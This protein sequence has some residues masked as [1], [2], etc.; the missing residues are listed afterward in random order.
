MASTSWYIPYL[1]AQGQL[2]LNLRRHTTRIATKWANSSNTI[3][4]ADK[5]IYIS[6]DI[7]E[8]TQ[9]THNHDAESTLACNRTWPNAPTM[10]QWVALNTYGGHY[11]TVGSGIALCKAWVWLWRQIFIYLFIYLFIYFLHISNS[12]DSHFRNVAGQNVSK[13]SCTPPLP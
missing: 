5:F 10:C 11:T 12:P 2:E 7:W 9:D 6:H 4:D 1:E 3:T 8:S 13:Q